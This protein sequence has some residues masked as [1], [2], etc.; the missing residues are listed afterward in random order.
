[1]EISFPCVMR[2][3]V[4]LRRFAAGRLISLHAKLRG[5]PLDVL[6]ACRRGF[7]GRST[8]LRKCGGQLLRG[9]PAC[10]CQTKSILTVGDNLGLLFAGSC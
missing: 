9:S 8:F 1:M 5:A 3:V 10:R 6:F 4:M 7:L 2:G